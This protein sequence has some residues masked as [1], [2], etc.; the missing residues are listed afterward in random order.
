MLRSARAALPALEWLQADLRSYR[1]DEPVD[2]L[3]ANAV[4]QW[5]PDHADLYPALLEQVKPGGALAIQVPYNFDE[6][7]HRAM[8]EVAGPWSAKT[9]G[10]RAS[11]AVQTPTFYYDLLATRARVV[12][13]WQTR[14]E[15]VMAD[16]HAIVE[17]VKGTGL[18][19][20]LE[21]VGDD[22]RS[23]YL[24]AYE[25]SIESAYP[26]RSDGRRLFSF[27]RLFLVAIR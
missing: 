19:P 5:L 14:Y 15:H 3:F 21:A 24:A 26:Q 6:P 18:R 20:F 8:R 27:P 2:V 1:V 7:S 12:D 10:V 9:A 17:W 25:R 4:M 23:A 13:I 11:P 22:E 16:A